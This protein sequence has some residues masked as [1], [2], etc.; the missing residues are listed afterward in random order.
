MSAD[1]SALSVAAMTIHLT[2]KKYLPIV[3][4][5]FTALGVAACGNDTKTRARP[6]PLVLDTVF[7]PKSM[8]QLDNGKKGDSAGDVTLGAAALRRSGK[9]YGRLELVDYAVDAP[10]EGGMQFL[11]LFLPRG[12]LTVQGG[13]VNKK[14]PGAGRSGTTEEFAVTG[15][16]SDYVGASGT[17]RVQHR[18]GGKDRIIVRLRD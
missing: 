7:D 5:A 11:T 12:T 18:D 10:Y 13:G 6:G 3:L 8:V 1:H 9:P 4:A 14:V 2:Y 17:I 15:G 16:T